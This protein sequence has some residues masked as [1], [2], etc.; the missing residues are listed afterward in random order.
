M[1][2]RKK[3]LNSCCC[4]DC[5]LLVFRPKTLLL[6]SNYYKRKILNGFDKMG[7]LVSQKI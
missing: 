5:T 7:G 1:I 2:I 3:N 4:N 6:A